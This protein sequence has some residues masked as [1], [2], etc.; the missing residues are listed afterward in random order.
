MPLNIKLNFVRLEMIAND[1][2]ILGNTLRMKYNNLAI[3]IIFV[4]ILVIECATHF[5]LLFFSSMLNFFVI[6]TTLGDFCPLSVL[7]PINNITE[8]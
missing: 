1:F 7:K 4:Q 6:K 2:Y 5:Q 8:I 3:F